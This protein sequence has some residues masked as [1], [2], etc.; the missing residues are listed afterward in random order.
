[1]AE[2]ATKVKIQVSTDDVAYNDVADLNSVTDSATGNTIEVT[3]FGDDWKKYI[4]GLNEFTMELD[5]Y[6]NSGD[7]NG[8][9]VLRDAWKNRTA[10][11]VQILYDGVNGVKG[12]CYVNKTERKATPSGTVDVTYSLTGTGDLTD[13]AG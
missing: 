9:I 2:D 11:Y 10:V 12:Q 4:A 13:V 1:M 6:W 5:G 3:A 7:T 8:Q